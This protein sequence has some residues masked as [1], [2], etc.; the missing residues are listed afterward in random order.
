MWG[1]RSKPDEVVSER[2]ETDLLTKREL[3]VRMESELEDAIAKLESF[4][5]NPDVVAIVM[6]VAYR[7][8]DKPGSYL[9]DAIQTGY[10]EAIPEVSKGLY[11]RAIARRDRSN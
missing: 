1:S 7:D 2:H 8:P 6:G 3:S 11:D 5:G 4:R 9:V 10:Q